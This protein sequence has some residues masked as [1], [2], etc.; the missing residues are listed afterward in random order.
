[1][2]IDIDIFDDEGIESM[3]K[4]GTGKNKLILTNNKE[5]INKYSEKNIYINENPFKR[6]KIIFD[7]NTVKE[8]S[9]Y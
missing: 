2:N 5:I 9:S 7:E 3:L 4:Y 1:M 8:I 6:E